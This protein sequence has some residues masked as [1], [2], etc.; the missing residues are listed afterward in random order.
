MFGEHS[1]DV[2]VLAKAEI[3]WKNSLYTLYQNAMDS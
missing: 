2:A 3:G 1:G